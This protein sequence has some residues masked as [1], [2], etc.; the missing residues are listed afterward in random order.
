M[1][2]RGEV[3]LKEPIKDGQTLRTLLDL[4]PIGVAIA[5]DVCCED[6]ELNRVAARILDVPPGERV[7]FAGP[8]SEKLPFSVRRGGQTVPVSQLPIC[9]AARTGELLH[10]IEVE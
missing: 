3:I 4:L 8:K 5:R 1:P 7:A 6:G 10:G 9:E 2:E